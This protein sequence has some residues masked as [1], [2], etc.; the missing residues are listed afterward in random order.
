MQ[1]LIEKL[2]FLARS[3][4]HKHV[5]NKLPVAME[6]LIADIFQETKLIAP[7]HQVS[8]DQNET[9]TVYADP[10]YL[11]EMLRV[12]IENSI[13]YTPEGGT[14]RLASQKTNQHL[15]ISVTD[16][17]IGIPEEDQPKIFDRFYRV[18][19]SRSKATGGAGLGLSI[20]HW[21]A[22]QHSCSI[23]LTST[24]GTGTIVTVQIPCIDN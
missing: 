15:T 7:N 17:G 6:P 20:A 12:F 1:K 23:Q 2:L 18:D 11:K 21:I 16:T 10:V 8:L 19:K 9:A 14:I 24:P 5:I 4:K 3:D 13:K 22:E